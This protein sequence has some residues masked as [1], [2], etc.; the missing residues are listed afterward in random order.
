MAYMRQYHSVFETTIRQLAGML[1]TYELTGK[2]YPVLVTKSQEVANKMS[3]AWVG[4]RARVLMYYWDSLQC[5]IE[6]R[7]ALRL[8]RLQYKHSTDRDCKP[9][10]VLALVV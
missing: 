7:G 1:A 3:V 4:V 5:P 8:C 6:Q 9:Y 10:I 2:Q